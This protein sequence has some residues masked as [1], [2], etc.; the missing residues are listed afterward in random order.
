MT[1]IADLFLTGLAAVIWGT[2]YLVTT[3]WLPGGYPLTTSLIRALPAGLLL[4]AFVRELPK[5]VWL[6]R[7]FVLAG[8]NFSLFWWLLFISAYRLPGGV[9]ATVN[10]LQPVFVVP[11]S[12]LLLGAPLRWATVGAALGGVV[13]VALLVVQ[14]GAT[15]DALGVAAGLGAAAAMALGTVLAK[16]WQPPVSALTFTAWQLVA[17]GLM[18]APFA[19]TLE[20]PLPSPT[21]PNLAGF[22]WLALFG[23]AVSY[24]LWFRGL[25]R[26]G[27]Q[28]VS[29]LVLI[30]PLTAILLGWLV[31]G[32]TFT[33]IQLLGVALVMISVSLSQRLAAPLSAERGDRGE[34]EIRVQERGSQWSR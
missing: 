20:P 14:P 11:L 30:S 33:E 28:A 29:P 17:G 18:L 16:R 25:A 23:A 8:L 5:G 32:E 19:L 22:V 1:R 12:W 2:V 3:R 26:L 21:L 15:L 7:V 27:P 9:A 13:G 6:F 4:L 31:A 10:A 24:F 34:P